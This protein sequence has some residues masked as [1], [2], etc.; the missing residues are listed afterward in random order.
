MKMVSEGQKGEDY[1]GKGVLREQIYP[2][3]R[4][5]YVIG[6]HKW[7]FVYFQRILKD[8]FDRWRRPN[9]WKYSIE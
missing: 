5:R 7:P 1:E 2:L 8:S 6:E 4:P 3:K 9:V